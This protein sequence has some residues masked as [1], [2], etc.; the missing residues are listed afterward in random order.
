MSANTH[1]LKDPD[2][3]GA[4]PAGDKAPAA[5]SAHAEINDFLLRLIMSPPVRV[6]YIN[7]DGGKKL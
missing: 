3:F 2:F 7:F 5:P 4:A 6:L 1:T